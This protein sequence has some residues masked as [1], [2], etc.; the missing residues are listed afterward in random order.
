MDVQT[1]FAK[2]LFGQI[3]MQMIFRNVQ[4][5]EAFCSKSEEYVYYS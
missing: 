1:V 4:N 3:E 5:K 2:K